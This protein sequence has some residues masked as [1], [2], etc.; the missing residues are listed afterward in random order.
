V[1]LESN[2]L[3]TKSLKAD[4]LL[5]L[6]NNTKHILVIVDDE[7][8]AYLPDEDLQFLIGILTACKLSM[9]DTALINFNK[10]PTINYKM[11]MK[12]FK[13][14]KVICLGID[15]AA[16]EFPL[17]F[18]HYQVQQY[19]QQSYLAAPSLKKLA[20]DKQEKLQLWNCLKKLFSI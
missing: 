18:P 20:S 14:E 3:K 16:L 19:N 10:N 8:A 5:Y 7:N 15:L 6:G 2:Q 11:L 17:Q 4:G 13:P 12:Q 9:S 1:D